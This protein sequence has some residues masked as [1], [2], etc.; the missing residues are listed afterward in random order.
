[1]TELP[2]GIEATFYE[3]LSEGHEGYVREG[4]RSTAKLIPIHGWFHRSIEE[5]FGEDVLDVQSLHQ[6]GREAKVEGHYYEKKVDIAVFSAEGPRRDGEEPLLII[7]LKFAISS[8]KKNVNNYFEHLMGETMNLRRAGIAVAAF[9]VLPVSCPKLNAAGDP[10]GNPDVLVDGDLR[11]YSALFEDEG[12][13]LGRPD[14]LGIQ[15]VQL[16]DRTDRNPGVAAPTDYPTNGHGKGLSDEMRN[17]IESKM[18]IEP[19]MTEVFGILD[20]K[21]G[22]T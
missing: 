18:S 1:M 22:S 9:S 16:P 4:A 14:A 12:N 17:F 8:L 19:F 6:G 13:D 20:A 11:K 21:L 7:S 10:T 2:D 5:S 15:L 3:A